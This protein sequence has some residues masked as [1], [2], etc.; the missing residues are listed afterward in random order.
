MRK[1]KNEETTT[2][3]VLR[4]IHGTVRDWA[5]RFHKLGI[6]I[7][8]E[9]KKLVAEQQHTNELLKELL[10]RGPA[11]FSV[12]IAVSDT[13]QTHPDTPPPSTKPSKTVQDAMRFLQQHP[14]YAGKSHRWIANQAGTPFSASTIRR[15]QR[16]LE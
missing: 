5:S 10:A 15:A 14:E 1:G 9:Q 16:E 11:S 4:K 6:A 2:F 3:A 8:D 13:P 7:L 12:P